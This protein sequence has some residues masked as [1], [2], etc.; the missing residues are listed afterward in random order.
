MK[1]IR[2]SDILKE[3]KLHESVKKYKREKYNSPQAVEG[4]IFHDYDGA[5]AGYY[6]SRKIL[7]IEGSV[8]TIQTVDTFNGTTHLKGSP[9][10]VHLSYVEKQKKNM[11]KKKI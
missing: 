3:S 9:Y 4:Q 6:N 11:K 8:A 10:T 7:K 2:I 5:K 1:I